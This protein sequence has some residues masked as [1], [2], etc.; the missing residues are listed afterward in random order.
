[1][2]SAPVRPM[3]T[4][5]SRSCSSAVKFSANNGHNSRSSACTIVALAILS[6]HKMWWHALMSIRTSPEKH[7]I[8]NTAV[9]HTSRIKP[10]DMQDAVQAHI[11]PDMHAHSLCY[12]CNFTMYSCPSRGHRPADAWPA[13]LHV[14]LQGGAQRRRHAVQLA[15]QLAQL[16]AVAGVLERQDDAVRLLQQLLLLLVV[17]R[18]RVADVD[19]R[20]L[21]LRAQTSDVRVAT[22][23]S[24]L[25]TQV[26]WL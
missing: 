25:C 16:R 5:T 1:M 12:M 20:L 24:R 22:S 6:V 2:T 7:C 18:V 4:P 14:L 11:L 8:T 9:Q 23:D 15:R 3:M 17:Q 19:Q 13:H 21:G 26:N 10:Y